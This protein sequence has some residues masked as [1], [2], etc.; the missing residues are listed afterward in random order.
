ML[1]IFNN[2]KNSMS[3]GEFYKKQNLSQ[4]ETVNQCFSI[5]RILLLPGR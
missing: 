5:I 4:S 2:N 3:F 1:W